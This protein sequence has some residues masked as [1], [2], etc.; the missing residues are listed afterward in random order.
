MFFLVCVMV[1]ENINLCNGFRKYLLLSRR[2]L[3][4]DFFFYGERVGDISG[5]FLR[6]KD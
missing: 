5:K 1:L 6:G 3:R 4:K 2:M